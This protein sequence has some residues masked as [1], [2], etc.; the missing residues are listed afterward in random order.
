[1][2]IKLCPG[3]A[4]TENGFD[5]RKCVSYITQKKGELSEEEMNAIRNSGSVWGCD[6]CQRVC[7]ENKNKEL[8]G[9]NKF[10]ENLILCIKNEKISNREFKKKYAERAF[11]WR[12]KG[13]IDRNL[14]IINEKTID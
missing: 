13:V 1:M 9:I 14:S 10:R 2:C 6:I 12:G 3:G 4:L 7:P 11:S 8:T 5:E